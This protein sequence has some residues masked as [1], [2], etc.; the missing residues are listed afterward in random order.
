MIK[1]LNLV[2]KNI[3]QLIT[4]FTITTGLSAIVFV[5]MFN[6]AKNSMPAMFLMM[7]VPAISAFLTSFLFKES[8]KSYNWRPGK[9]KYI[10]FAILI[11]LSISIVVYGIAWIAGFI[12]FYPVEVINYR[13][14]GML[15]FS[16]PVPIFT[17]IM[18]KLTVGAAVIFVFVMG[19]E[20][21][22]SGFLT[23]KLLKE[24]SIAKTSIVVGIYWAIWHTPAIIG[25]FYGTGVPLWIQLPGFILALIAASF[26][27][28]ILIKKSKS[29]WPG[30]VLHLADNVILMGLFY[31]LTVKT[32][33]SGYLVSESGLLTGAVYLII[34]LI[35]LKMQ[36]K[37]NE[38]K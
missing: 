31:D 32:E 2:N 11:P 29:L 38:N 20:I 4:F 9:S 24:F 26:V 33:Y 27:R 7:W 13:W 14:A 8:I 6:G 15:G 1:K 25:G 5:W 18:S 21:G 22:W 36:L 17:G 3:E 37:L 23:P 28:T 12:S 34:S 35:L 10:L 19:E 16:L 30:V